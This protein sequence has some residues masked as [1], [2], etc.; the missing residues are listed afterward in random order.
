[1]SGRGV[2]LKRFKLYNKNLTVL[3]TIQMPGFLCKRI[4][5]SE[6]GGSDI[7][8]RLKVTESQRALPILSQL[9][10]T[11]EIS[12]WQLQVGKQKFGPFEWR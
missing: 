12:V 9:Q 7:A 10:K 1:M 8:P 4:K 2:L 6:N 3:E 11:Y 5:K